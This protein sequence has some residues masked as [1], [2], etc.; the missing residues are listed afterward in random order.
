MARHLHVTG[1][2]GMLGHDLAAAAVASGWTVSGVGTHDR[3]ALA[4][5]PE[6][7]YTRWTWDG[8]ATAADLVEL[9]VGEAD[10]V[11][12]A[13]AY[14]QV[15]KAEEDEA[16][17]LSINAHWTER[18]A[19]ACRATG[20]RLVYISTDYVFDGSRTTPWETGD[21]IAPLGAYGRTKAAGEAAAA[22]APDH[23][24][25]RTSWLFG[26]HGPN[27]VETILKAAAARPELWVVDDQHGCPTATT[28]LADA[29]LRL[30]DHRATGIFHLTN[31]GPTTWWGFAREIVRLGGLSTPVLTQSTAE[32][33]RP[34]PRPA[35]SVLSDAA[36]RALGEAPL[37]HWQD[38]LA[39]YMAHRPVSTAS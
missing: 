6:V 24:I 4:L 29:L 37:A 9:G 32:A 11:L 10:V 34:A 31:Q 17:A 26:H 7:R 36:W 20:K 39:R 27:F 35:R 8:T 30:Q 16:L 38:A 5:P 19:E 15:D 21:P 3:S 2:S 12:H 1:I 23:Q 14:T 22:T 28:D 13:A 25:V 33:G 18:L